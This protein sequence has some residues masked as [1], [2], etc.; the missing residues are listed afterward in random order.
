MNRQVPV[1][2]AA[3]PQEPNAGRRR[4]HREPG[5]DQP[6]VVDRDPAAVAACQYPTSR[7]MSAIPTSPRATLRSSSP[8]RKRSSAL[9]QLQTVASDY[10][11][12]TLDAVV[13]KLAHAD[14]GKLIMACGT[15]KTFT[16]LRIAETMAGVGGRALWLV[17]SL[18]FMSQIVKEWSNDSS[19]DIALCS[20]WS[21]GR[22]GRRTDLDGV[23]LN[24]R[25]AK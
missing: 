9:R 10:Q 24:K 12:E 25:I 6:A 20:A 23:G 3:P 11:R 13:G 17:P 5:L 8:S 16:A 21:D 4:H 15:C 2:P 19:L 18:A 7:S 22:M 14:R 1:V